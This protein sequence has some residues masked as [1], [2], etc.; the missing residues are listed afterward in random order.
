MTRIDRPPRLVNR[1]SWDFRRSPEI[2]DYTDYEVITR[3]TNALKN[4]EKSVESFFEICVIRER[5]VLFQSS[6]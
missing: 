2:P 5:K 6:S 4:N 3:I 1:N